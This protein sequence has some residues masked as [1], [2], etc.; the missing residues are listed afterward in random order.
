MQQILFHI[1]FFGVPIYG[2]GLMLFF[3][4]LC[5][6]W[7]AKR[8]CKWQGINGDF[9]PDLAI[10]LFVS[11]IP[12]GRAVYVSENWN[13]GLRPFSEWYWNSITDNS[14]LRAIALWDG[15]LVLYGSLLGGLIG[16]FVYHY[17]FLRKRGISVWKMLDV[18]APCIVIGIALGR[19]GCLCTGCCYGNVACEGCPAIHFPRPSGAWGAMVE[20]GHQTALGFLF[21]GDTLEVSAVEPGS[22]AEKA[23]LRAADILTEVEIDGKA[24]MVPLFR[25]ER[26]E[27]IK[28]PLKF[29]IHRNGEDKTLAPFTPVSIGVHP[30]QIYETISMCLLLFFML[31]YFPYRRREGELMVIFMFAYAVHR[32]LNEMLRTDTPP[33]WSG[34]T[35]SQNVSILLL[36][37]GVVL[38]VAVWRRPPIGETP[39]ET[40]PLAA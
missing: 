20:R 6:T 24:K 27:A 25:Q 32:Y 34:L 19:I 10:W 18:V 1:P 13:E 30:T 21:T 23:G 26:F 36:T 12:V 8:L 39:P 35:F 15:G 17:L 5:C 7:L 31:S 28:G 14:I 2:Y 40:P 37:A 33:T 4:Y 38:A 16:Y 9:I 29:T 11:A 3:S 22:P